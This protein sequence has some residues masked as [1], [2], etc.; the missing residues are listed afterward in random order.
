[1]NE[2]REK[3]KVL[4]IDDH[5]IVRNGLV[6]MINSQIDMAVVAQCTDASSGYSEILLQK[7]DVVVTDI[8]MPGLSP[9]EMVDKAKD[10]LPQLKV[11]FLTAFSTDGNIAR[12]MRAGG[13]GFVTKIDPIT[14]IL[15]AIREVM[16]GEAYYS[17][18]AKKLFVEKP[19]QETSENNGL[20]NGGGPVEL[21]VRK[22]L[23]SP[24]EVEVLCCVAK[25]STAKQI[26]DTLKISA[27]TVERH[28][29]NIMS[30]LEIHS[31]VDLARY[32]IREGLV[33]P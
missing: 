2:P 4:V 18:E 16:K 23:L 32:A 10:N 11:V 21:M 27:K 24:R 9:F 3:L 7:P 12:C 14:T 13:S 33:A 17:D 20:S 5:E 30:K 28:K 26:A 15:D 25:G 1:M 22:E 29:S 6:T 31:Q 19:H 8:S